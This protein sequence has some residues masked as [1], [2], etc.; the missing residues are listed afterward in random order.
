MRAIS[1]FMRRRTKLRRRG[2]FPHVVTQSQPIAYT[3]EIRKNQ[4][5]GVCYEKMF[6]HLQ[7]GKQTKSPDC[8]RGVRR[9]V[10]MF[11]LHLTDTACRDNRRLPNRIG[12]LVTEELL[13][14]N[15][16]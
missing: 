7:G 4:E 10:V 9:G 16:S 2:D 8:Y 1:R 6:K 15:K 11:L 14:Q 3:I 13:K 12:N 5:R